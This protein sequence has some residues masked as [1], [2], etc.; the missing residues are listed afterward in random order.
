MFAYV[1]AVVVDTPICDHN[2]YKKLKIVENIS[3]RLERVQIFVDYLDQ[4]WLSNGAHELFSDWKG[5]S[6]DIR[7]DCE[8]VQKRLSRIY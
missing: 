8:E 4:Q 7:Q 1:D 5:I 2:T 3:E 6:D